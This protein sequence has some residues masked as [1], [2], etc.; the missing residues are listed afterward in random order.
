ML[1][2][3]ILAAD[4]FYREMA[5]RLEPKKIQPPPRTDGCRS[6]PGTAARAGAGRGPAL[7]GGAAD[8]AFQPMLEDMDCIAGCIMYRFMLCITHNEPTTT[9]A[10]MSR[11]NTPIDR[12]LR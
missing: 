4:R 2:I 1:E 6:R 10:M 12:L 5:A 7:A 3:G 8:Q 11:V 9:M